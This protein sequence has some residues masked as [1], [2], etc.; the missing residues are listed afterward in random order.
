MAPGGIS[1]TRLRQL[2]NRF[3]NVLQG[4]GYKAG[5]RVFVLAGRIPELYISVLGTLKHRSVS[6]TLFSAFGP[7]PI[8]TRLTMG[9]AQVLVATETLYRKKI[10][11][12]RAGLPLLKHVILIGD[13][14]Q[15]TAVP[16]S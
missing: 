14:G 13:H 3:A 8:H 10:A 11:D 6:C 5:A 9:G 7:E 4:L 1:L 15:R 2:T 12:L 16:G